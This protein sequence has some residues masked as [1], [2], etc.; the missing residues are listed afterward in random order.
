ME[1]RWTQHSYNKTLMM[2][3][4][5]KVKNE[6]DFNSTKIMKGITN[7]ILRVSNKLINMYFI[8]ILYIK[9]VN[10]FELTIS[11]STYP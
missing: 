8:S 1:Q 3:Q 2:E 9:K 5:E 11:P 4:M 10:C 6:E 7:N